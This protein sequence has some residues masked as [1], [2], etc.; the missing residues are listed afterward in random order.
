VSLQERWQT[1][2][3][4]RKVILLCYSALVRPVLECRIQFWAPQYED[5]TDLLKQI[6]CRATKTIKGPHHLLY[7]ERLRELGLFSLEEKVP[8]GSYCL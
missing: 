6:Q 4:I 3:S 1:A 7:V 5:D 8:G 2:F